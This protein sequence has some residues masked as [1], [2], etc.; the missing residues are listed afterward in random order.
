VRSTSRRTTARTFSRS[1]LRLAIVVC[2]FLLGLAPSI[3]A[4]E[5]PTSTDADVLD[6]ADLQARWR[7]MKAAALLCWRNDVA[8]FDK[9]E[10]AVALDQTLV[11]PPPPA[12][13]Q[14]AV[15]VALVFDGMYAYPRDAWA[16]ATVRLMVKKGKCDLA[17]GA[18]QEPARPATPRRA[19][20]A[21][22]TSPQLLIRLA[23]TEITQTAWPQDWEELEHIRT[24]IDSC[25]AGHK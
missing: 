25:T 23:E 24:R 6:D 20:L 8:C 17:T 16:F 3:R 12:A 9:I 18:W 14:P 13:S 19:I 22:S 4:A 7:S 1:P 2:V 15:P 5:P 21:R 10:E 11:M